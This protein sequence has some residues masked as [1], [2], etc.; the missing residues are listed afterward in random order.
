[1]TTN[2]LIVNPKKSSLATLKGLLPFLK[3]YKREFLLAGIAL[4]IAA[5]ATLA[6]PYAFRQMID[7]GFG[8]ASTT[9]GKNIQ[10]VDFYFLALFGV[11]QL[12]LVLAELG[13]GERL[14]VGLR[15]LAE[16]KLIAWASYA[17]VVLALGQWFVKMISK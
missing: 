17:I 8:D 2:A 7:L 13:Y 14:A 3:P 4:L 15:R 12:M 11:A 16:P 10:H 1:M 5:G 6:I 9:G